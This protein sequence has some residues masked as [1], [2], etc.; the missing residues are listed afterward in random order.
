VIVGYGNEQRNDRATLRQLAGKITYQRAYA[1]SWRRQDDPNDYRFGRPW[2]MVNG[3]ADLD[4]WNESY[5]ENLRDYLG[6]ARDCGIVVG[7]TIWDGHDDLPGG[8]FGIDS[9]WNAAYNLQGVQWAYNLD[10]LVKY[11]EPRPAGGAGERLVYYQRRWIERL[12]SE[13][14]GY[15]NVIIELDNETDQAPESWWLWWAGYFIKKGHSVIATT[16][17][18]AHTISDATFST[19][20]RLHMKSY[21]VRSDDS[22]T[23]E[24]LSWNKVIVADAD[25][26][27]GNLDGDTARKF[28]W[29]A[30]IRG[31]HWNDFVCSGKAFPDQD[32]LVYYGNLLDFLQKRRVPVWDMTPAD[33]VAS[34]GYALAKSGEQYLIYV[35]GDVRVD[36]SDA[37]GL[38]Q[39]EWYDP[40]RGTLVESGQV[41]GG[42][43]RTFSS[44][45]ASH[46][47]LD[48]VRPPS[49]DFVLWISRSAG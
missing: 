47:L 37:T 44:P 29:R 22:I 24:R 2:P 13:I 7:L 33:R 23:S 30:V 15:P 12:A 19:D 49:R 36:L 32:K 43:P 42:A 5:W 41:Q 38:L 1:A 27:C 39:Y 20:P 21:H 48:V 40:R 26:S 46:S 34:E 14:K 4:R 35:E 9:I 10:D 45:S 31:G 18:A 8:Q 17:N 28:A 3:K 16:W 11:P 6:N 25:D